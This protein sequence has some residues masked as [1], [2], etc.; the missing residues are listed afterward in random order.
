MFLQ[1]TYFP[2]TEVPNM[3]K[4][5]KKNKTIQRIYKMPFEMTDFFGGGGGKAKRL[6]L[7]NS[8]I[9]SKPTDFF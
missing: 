3:L 9:F 4:F 1:I 8:M 7:N 6:I 2:K 5:L